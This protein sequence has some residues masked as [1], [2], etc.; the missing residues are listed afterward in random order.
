MVR[1][2]LK[3]GPGSF[4][5]SPGNLGPVLDAFLCLSFP[6]STMSNSSSPFIFKRRMLQMHANISHRNRAIALA[7]GQ[8][9]VEEIP[10][11]TLQEQVGTSYPAH[12]SSHPAQTF[13]T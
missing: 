12:H 5:T 6:I 2:K 10:L 3:A 1:A 9:C 4:T 8:V 7:G 13:I 11:P